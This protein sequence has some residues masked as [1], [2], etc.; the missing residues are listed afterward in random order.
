MRCVA[1]DEPLSPKEQS[2][3]STITGEDFL[4]CMKCLN[5]AGLL[6]AVEESPIAEEDVYFDISKLEEGL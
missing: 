5:E 3:K 2:M 1:C 6:Q 4:L